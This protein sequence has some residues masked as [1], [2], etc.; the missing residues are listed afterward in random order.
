MRWAVRG[1]ARHTLSVLTRHISQKRAYAGGTCDLQDLWNEDVRFATVR[2]SFDIEVPVK[3]ARLF[4]VQET[5]R[6]TIEQS[7]AP[8][9]ATLN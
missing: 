7:V 6:S 8:A 4:K 3:G 1:K 5:G 2:H 9:G